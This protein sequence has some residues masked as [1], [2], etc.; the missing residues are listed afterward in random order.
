MV[1]TEED[2]MRKSPFVIVML[3]AYFALGGIVPSQGGHRDSPVEYPDGYRSWTQVKTMFIQEGHP[4]YEAFGGVHHVYGN[5]KALKGYREARPFPDGSVIVFDLMEA[6]YVGNAVS[7]GERKVLAVM[8]KNSLVYQDTGGWGL[9]A[10]KGNTRE[11]V[12]RDPKKECF[13]CHEA[14]RGI[15][16]VYSA[17]RN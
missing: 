13:G 3:V 11:R 12:V 1:I 10:F 9:E 4:L 6:R 7:E 14:R 15:D 8:T 16:Y 17:Y 5:R 2:S